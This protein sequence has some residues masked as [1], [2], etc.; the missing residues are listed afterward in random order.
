M[1]LPDLLVYEDGQPL[2]IPKSAARSKAEAVRVLGE[3]FG[4]DWLLHDL[5]SEW[6]DDGE[7]RYSVAALRV[8][9]QEAVDEGHMCRPADSEAVNP[10][11][12]WTDCVYPGLIHDDCV[13]QCFPVW[14]FAG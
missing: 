2:A 14:R 1:T 9:V 8:F 12:P 10:E 5:P 3:E 7:V 4:F 11:Y 6:D 13:P